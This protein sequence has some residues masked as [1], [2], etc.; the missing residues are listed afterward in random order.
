MAGMKTC[1]GTERMFWFDCGVDDKNTAKQSLAKPSTIHILIAIPM[2][3][4]SGSY[5]K[6]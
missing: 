3:T 1:F 6:T 4:H 5:F 2:L